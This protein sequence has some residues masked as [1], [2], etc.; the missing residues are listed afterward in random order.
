MYLGD[1]RIAGEE[2]ERIAWKAG[3]LTLEVRWALAE[4]P[5]LLD[6]PREPLLRWHVDDPGAG[7]P[8]ELRRWRFRSDQVLRL[9]V[10]LSPPGGE[11]TTTRG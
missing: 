2:I 3:E 9:V 11:R 10:V 7:I 5:V 1:L 8:V 6:L 4:V